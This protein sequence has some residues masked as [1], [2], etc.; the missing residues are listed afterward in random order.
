MS[1]RVP[2]KKIF[3][4]ASPI[5]KNVL[6]NFFPG[7]NPP[8]LPGVFFPSRV[9]PDLLCLPKVEGFLPVLADDLFERLFLN[10]LW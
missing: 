8:T 5:S 9:P 2:P 4:V 1:H 6:E 7:I 3:C 10:K